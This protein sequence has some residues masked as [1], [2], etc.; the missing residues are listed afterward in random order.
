MKF[1]A[2]LLACLCCLSVLL[3]LTS[4]NEDDSTE[5]SIFGYI[6]V[7]LIAFV[8]FRY[9]FETD[10]CEPLDNKTT[11]EQELEEVKND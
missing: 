8:L 7:M 11:I 3:S 4:V 2:F 10:N 6:L 9:S 1:V 5:K